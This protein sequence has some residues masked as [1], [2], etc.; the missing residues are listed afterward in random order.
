MYDP[1]ISERGSPKS[2]DLA[3]A[4]KRLVTGDLQPEEGKFSE[5]S[6]RP[7]VLEDFVGQAQVLKRETGY[8]DKSCYDAW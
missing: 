3:D 5:Q 6:L 8:W 1:E 4:S 7:R 2:D